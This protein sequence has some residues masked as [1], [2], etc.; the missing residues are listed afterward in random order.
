MT[1]RTISR[2]EWDLLDL[3]AA[4][5][6]G[7]VAFGADLSADSLLTAY[8]AGLYP[9]P[10]DTVEQQL[11][12][13]LTYEAGI[14]AKRIRVLSGVDDPF[15]IAWCSPDPRPLIPVDQLH[16][17]RSLRQ[18]L[19][20]KTDWTTTMNVR[21]ARVVD[22][23]RTG[24]SQRWLTDELVDGLCR[25]HERGHAHS[26]EVWDG[27]ELVGGTFG[28]RIGAVFSADS[29]FT[30][31]SGAGKV[32]VADLAHRFAEAGGAVVDVQH[33]GDHVR[34][35]GARPVPRADYLALLG[36]S[37]ECPLPAEP[38]PAR[39]LAGGRG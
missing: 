23:C 20:N 36:S 27:A 13:E 39:R 5:A 22:E 10:A 30:R 17:Q 3:A 18:Q 12:N 11:I 29:Q 2:P 16:L 4:P 21:F 15:A 26:V 28:V 31:R 33:D 8:R 24:R 35:M 14:A 34:L 32:A 1:N 37:A 7:P 25:L 38:R 19:R 9:F 6:E